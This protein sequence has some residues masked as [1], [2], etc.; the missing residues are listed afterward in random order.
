MRRPP[1]PPFIYIEFK[2]GRFWI[3]NKKILGLSVLVLGVVGVQS[4]HALTTAQ[5]Q[6]LLDNK[7]SGVLAQQKLGTRLAESESVSSVSTVQ[8]RA[9]T[10]LRR[11]ARVVWE[12]SICGNV[13]QNG[14]WC[15]PAGGVALPAKSIITRSF[16]N[17][18][19][20]TVSTSGTGKLTF[21]CSNSAGDIMQA[22]T[23]DSSTV[24][25]SFQGLQNGEPKYM[26]KLATQCTIKS[27]I[28]TNSIGSGRVVLFV[29]YVIAE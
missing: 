1:A 23:M 5:Q 4:S 24:G 28:T 26:T 8:A 25:E 29:E 27:K 20:P 11:T 12:A 7:T 17:I 16:I 19:T 9:A 14:G 6:Y 13:N 15:W 2:L 21:F 18:V 3:M 22:T 10:L